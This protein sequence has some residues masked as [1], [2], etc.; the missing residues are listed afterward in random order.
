[1]PVTVQELRDRRERVVRERAEQAARRAAALG[2]DVWLGLCLGCDTFTV[3]LPKR[4]VAHPPRQCRGCGLTLRWRRGTVAP[5]RTFAEWERA[6]AAL[7]T[8]RPG[9]DA[10]GTETGPGSP[11]TP[12]GDH[13]SVRNRRDE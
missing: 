8:G 11:E 2:V 10:T 12:G 1:M 13:V 6:N 5:R 3:Y 7:L 9:P 4:P